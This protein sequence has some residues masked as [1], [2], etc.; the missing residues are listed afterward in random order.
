MHAAQLRPMSRW[1]VPFL[2]ASIAQLERAKKTQNSGHV[3][4]VR[5]TTSYEH[6]VLEVPGMHL[7]GMV[8]TSVE[9]DIEQLWPLSY[10]FWFS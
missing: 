8:G 1:S 4:T 6:Y 10:L 5:S 3:I 9:D 2:S 7:C